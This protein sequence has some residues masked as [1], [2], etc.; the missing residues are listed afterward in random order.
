MKVTQHICNNRIYKVFNPYNPKMNQFL[1]QGAYPP[2]DQ[3]SWDSR[4]SKT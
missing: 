4:A 3:C 1:I 2:Q